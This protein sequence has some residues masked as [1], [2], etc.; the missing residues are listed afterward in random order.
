[1]RYKF[2]IFVGLIA[3]VLYFDIARHYGDLV[4]QNLLFSSHPPTREQLLIGRFESLLAREAVHV[5]QKKFYIGFNGAI[6]VILKGSALLGEL[7]LTGEG[8]EVGDVDV[9]TSLPELWG[10]FV[11][12][13]REETA[14]ERPVVDQATW[15]QVL[16]AADRVEERVESIGGNAALIAKTMSFH[17]VQVR[18]R[19]EFR[20]R[21]IL[22]FRFRSGFARI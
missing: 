12:Y 2:G 1:M 17:P 5:K 19:P 4:L 7:P 10:V 3:T 21:S 22:A 6:D 13:L 8:R 14:A 15:E 9:V 18:T 20:F 11:H 16:E